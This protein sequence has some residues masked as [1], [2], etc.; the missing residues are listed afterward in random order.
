[1]ILMN[2]SLSEGHLSIRLWSY[3]RGQVHVDTAGM[4]LYKAPELFAALL[5]LFLRWISTVATGRR[6]RP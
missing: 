3:R 4:Y 2:Y 5:L 6:A 1:M